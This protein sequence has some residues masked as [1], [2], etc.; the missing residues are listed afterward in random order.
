MAVPRMML[1]GAP[2]GVALPQPLSPSDVVLVRRIFIAQSRG[3]LA[4]A[5]RSTAELEN[6]LL[7]GHILADRY[8]GPFHRSSVPELT[9][10][11]DRFGNQP[12]AAAIYSLLLQRLP[13]GAVPPP[14]P[15]PATMLGTPA[16][17]GRH[18]DDDSSDDVP[19][20][21]NAA[22]DHAVIVQVNSGR[23]DAALRMIE[24]RP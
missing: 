21:R 24:S 18:D 1:P 5:S 15:V 20:Q 11:L 23:D 9:D 7:L 12:D 6:P 3:D 17:A 22:L 10:W 16:A 13:K 4:L 2:G 8:L 14:A 19:I